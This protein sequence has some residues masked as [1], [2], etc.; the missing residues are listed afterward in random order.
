MTA[1][2]TK[3]YRPDNRMN[4]STDLDV[5]VR[6]TWGGAL[7]HSA[8]IQVLALARTEAL[9]MIQKESMTG[10]LPGPTGEWSTE[11][12]L[13]AKFRI[14]GTAPGHLTWGLMQA[15]VQALRVVLVAEKLAKEA[16]CTLLAG[17]SVVG[18]L[19][20]TKSGANTV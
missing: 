11:G 14:V 17:T 5:K 6:C 7:S 12:H 4:P 16:A 13:G 1:V 20:V 8:I 3:T 9:S 15:G 19:S 10:L 2:L 18:A